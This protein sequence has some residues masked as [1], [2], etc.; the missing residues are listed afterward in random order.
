MHTLQGLVTDHARL[1]HH[2]VGS[3][4]CV[5][6]KGVGIAELRQCHMV[7]AGNKYPKLHYVKNFSNVNL[8]LIN[9]L[10]LM[11]QFPTG[12]QKFSLSMEVSS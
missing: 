8:Y 7:V 11:H 10:M 6:T 4:W 1:L 2:Q 9:L 3:G 12:T 5:H